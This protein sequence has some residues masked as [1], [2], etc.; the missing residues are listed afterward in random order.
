M[1]GQDKRYLLEFDR[2]HKLSEY[3]IALYSN[4][5]NK[6]QEVKDDFLD[7]LIFAYSFGT[8]EAYKLLGVEKKEPK[9]DKMYDAIYKNIAGKNFEQRVDDEIDHD[10]ELMRLIDSEFHRVYN[11]ALFD[12]A[13]DINNDPQSGKAGLIMKTWIT[14]GDDRVRDT[15]DY[16][17]GTTIPLDERFYTYDDDSARYPG[18][19]TLASNNCLC[20]CS[21]SFSTL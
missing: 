8:A 9:K 15:H 11:T 20:R 21:I 18:D 12:T 10:G 19:F 7:F 3:T 17:E 16:L 14:M 5:E 6:R 1:N 2:I 4:S 13:D